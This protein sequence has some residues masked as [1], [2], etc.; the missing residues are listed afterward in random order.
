MDPH[1]CHQLRFLKNNQVSGEKDGPELPL[2]IDTA[3]TAEDRHGGV[4][5]A[6]GSND[7]LVSSSSWRSRCTMDP[8]GSEAE[9]VVSHFLV[10]DHIAD[11]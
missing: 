11:C 4:V 9:M 3:R 8:D 5:L 10:P 6:G 7:Y 1:L 2:G